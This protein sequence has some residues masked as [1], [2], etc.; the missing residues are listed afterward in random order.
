ML[1]EKKKIRLGCLPI[2]PPGYSFQLQ[3]KT[4]NLF[5]CIIFHEKKESN[6]MSDL[7]IFQKMGYFQPVTSHLYQ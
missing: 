4:F 5:Q 2:Q 7:V 3:R 1:T 6:K